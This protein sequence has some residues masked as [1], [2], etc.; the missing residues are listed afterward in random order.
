MKKLLL[1]LSFFFFCITAF[2]QPADKIRGYWLTEKGTSQVWI[3]KAKNGNYYGKLV[4]L[5]EPAEFG[6][7]K[8]DK[9]NPDDKLKDRP[10]LDLLLLKGFEYDAEDN[11][12]E[13]GTIYDPESGKTYDAYMWFEDGNDETLK[14]KGFV[15]GMRFMGRET[16][17][18][19]EEKKRGS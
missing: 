13:N 14:I 4:W 6:A 2:S 3:Y 7:P 17:W 1:S 15:M 11:E 8:K 5:E 18:K 12:W 9:E 10:L 16:T 19:K